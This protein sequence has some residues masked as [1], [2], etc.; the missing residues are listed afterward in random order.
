MYKRPKRPI[1]PVFACKTR[2]GTPPFINYILHS[3]KDNQH[4]LKYIVSEI[5]QA[6]MKVNN[7]IWKTRC[8]K[9][10]GAYNNSQRPP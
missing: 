8:K 3:N 10:Y 7:D 2:R 6:M 1:G 9:L 5:S 4:R